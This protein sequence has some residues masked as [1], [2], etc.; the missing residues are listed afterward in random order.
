MSFLLNAIQRFSTAIQNKPI[1]ALIAPVIAVV[2][3][4]KLAMLLL[5]ILI[6]LDFV[7]GVKKHCKEKGVRI[8]LTKPSTWKNLTSKG[9]RNTYNKVT[10]YAL[11]ILIVAF[12]QAVWFPAFQPLSY[13][14]ISGGITNVVVLIACSIESWSIIEN[15]LV[16]K[17]NSRFLKK[18]RVVL[19]SVN[20]KF[21]RKLDEL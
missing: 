11:G 9:F 8:K 19:E 13:L 18:M 15:M 12:F 1:V 16:V 14:G 21:K 10:E 6:T 3:E 20:K 17:P 2:L 5:T 7:Y 4:L